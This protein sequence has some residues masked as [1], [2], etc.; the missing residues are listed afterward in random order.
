MGLWWFVYSDGLEH[1]LRDIISS[2]FSLKA[3]NYLEIK[4]PHFI[5]E[6]A[7]Q[8]ND[9]VA[10]TSLETYN[11][12]CSESSMTDRNLVFLIEMATLQRTHASIT[13]LVYD[14]V[15]L[16]NKPVKKVDMLNWTYKKKW[17]LLYK[18]LLHFLEENRI[19]HMKKSLLRKAWHICQM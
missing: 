10:C 15:S 2:H 14:I 9:V 5:K 3:V 13:Q 4:L 16:L 7:C 11:K 8:F 19:F 12:G 17:T 18:Q 1:T 6:D